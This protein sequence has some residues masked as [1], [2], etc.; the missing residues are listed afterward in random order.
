MQEPALLMA[1]PD[2]K[3]THDVEESAI[4]IAPP[5][6]ADGLR[7]PGIPPTTFDAFGASEQGQ[8]AITLRPA[9]D[10]GERLWSRQQPAGRQARKDSCA[11]KAQATLAEARSGRCSGRAATAWTLA[12]PSQACKRS[13][14]SMT[15][16]PAAVSPKSPPHDQAAAR[17]ASAS[18]T[19][20]S[21]G[22]GEREAI[23]A[24]HAARA[25]CARVTGRSRE[26][27]FEGG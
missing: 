5:H 9:T 10:L 17:G 12:S 23:Q 26:G 4:V 3:A 27:Q 7:F 22:G 25:R 6:Q 20:V 1:S 14:S 15:P 18:S 21:T 16:S 2:P 13:T 24:V 11:A 19:R 8:R